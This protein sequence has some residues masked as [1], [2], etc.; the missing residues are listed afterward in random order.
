[1]PT[2]TSL[3]YRKYLFIKQFR[4]KCL[5]IPTENYQKSYY[6]LKP[7]YLKIVTSF[8]SFEFVQTQCSIEFKKNKLIE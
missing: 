7:T 3:W 1:M 2:Y 5:S 8:S 6:S 4:S